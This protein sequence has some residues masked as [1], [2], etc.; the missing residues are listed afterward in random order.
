MTD[1]TKK[2]ETG[3]ECEALKKERD[4]Y[5]EGWK[6]AKADFINY[7]KDEEIRLKNTLNLQRMIFAEELI[8]ILESVRL[9][10]RAW[11]GDSPEKT[12]V[13][14]VRPQME[15]ALKRYGGE[16]IPSGAGKAFDP[17]TSECIEMVEKSE[18]GSGIVV[19]E[20]E[21]GYKIEGKVIKPAK[22]KVAQ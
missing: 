16:R 13:E 11:K 2:E 14:L 22:V 9:G 7:K 12:G 17:E 15:D 6:R 1:E 21:P 20:A 10:L 3:N 5:L 8:R 19:E 4:E 18:V